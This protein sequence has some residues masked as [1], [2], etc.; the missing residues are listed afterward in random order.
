MTLKSDERIRKTS[1]FDES[2]AGKY[3]RELDDK[4]AKVIENLITDIKEASI[5]DAARKGGTVAMEKPLENPMT[6]QM[7]TITQNTIKLVEPNTWL[8][9]S[10][11][12]IIEEM[13]YQLLSLK[14]DENCHM[15]QVD[16]VLKFLDIAIEKWDD[17]VKYTNDL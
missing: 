3:D 1:P 10:S 9:W 2:S 4:R 12:R 15:V 11:K 16:D 5:K 17:T 14:H 6:V 13:W 8:S 7:E